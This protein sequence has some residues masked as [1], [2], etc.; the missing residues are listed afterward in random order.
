MV[1]PVLTQELL[2]GSRRSRQHLFRRIYTGWLVVQLLFFYFLYLIDAN[3]LGSW[4][5]S[6][7][8]N[9][10]ATTDF[11][12]SLI[13]KLISQQ[14]ILLL[15]AT[16]AFTAGAITDEKA[17]GT[18]QYLLAADLTAW[19]IIVGKLLGRAAQVAI[20]ALAS[21]PVLC[22]MG[23]FGG[24]SLLFVAALVAV[25]V[26]PMFALGSA[27]LL[28]S[29]WS[30][31]TRD[32]VLGVYLAALVGY[33]VFW[34]F[35]WLSPFD[36]LYALDP[37][38]GATPDIKEL[39][40]RLLISALAWGSIGALCLALATWRLRAAYLKQLEGEGRPRKL[41]WWRA[42]RAPI[43]DEP[44]RWKERHVEGL[45][46]LAVLRRIP[47]WIGLLVVFAGTFIG[48]AAI[49]LDNIQGHPTLVDTLMTIANLKFNLLTVPS[50]ATTDYFFAQS[51]IALLVAT[52]VVG[53]RCSGAVTGERERQTWEALLMTPLPSP[54]LIRGKLWGI[55]GASYPYLLAYA[56]PALLF[57]LWGGFEPFFMTLLR[58]AVTWLAMA[59]V[60]TAGLW[61]SVRSKSSW[62]SLLGTVLIGYLGGFFLLVVAFP[63]AGLLYLLILLTLFLVD[64]VTGNAGGAGFART[65]SNYSGFYHVGVCVALIGAF[66]LAIKLFLT[67]AQQYV[68]LRERIRHWKEEP[69]AYRRVYRRRPQ[70]SDSR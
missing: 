8:I 69:R 37:A 16:P 63:V 23:V 1:G 39:A 44:I 18:L 58:L 50:G 5:F 10:Y 60:G 25:T 26:A 32:A 55:I 67:T 54:H 33:L 56:I 70:P 47:R 45:A 59:F 34:Y 19:E 43:S 11:A 46:P 12:T 62:R 31:Q 49:I 24:V 64:V 2:L 21:L 27:S 65:F 4:L 14:F 38:W 15:L 40:R 57:S 51:V 9:S 61:C 20:L 48:S 6:G 7:T 52:L 30:R 68:A 35:G 29:V 28:A 42:R 36:P 3:V 53:L 13:G 66:L 22:F 41:R 17:S